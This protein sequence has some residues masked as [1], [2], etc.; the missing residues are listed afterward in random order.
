MD[1]KIM[2]GDCYE[3]IKEIPDKSIDLVITDPPYD[4]GASHGSGIMRDPTSSAYLK[5]IEA[6]GINK[7]FDLSLLDELCRVMKKINIYIWCSKAQVLKLCNYFI[8]KG[9]TFEI[10]IWEKQNPPPL[11]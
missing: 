6:A 4:I 7:G 8:N 1:S 9:C 10:L 5:Q 2:L 3:L 11:C